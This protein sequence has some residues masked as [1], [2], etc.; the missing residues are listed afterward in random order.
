MVGTIGPFRLLPSL[1]F[2]MTFSC[3]QIRLATINHLPPNLIY[4]SASETAKK[5]VPQLR[6]QG[7]EIIIA[8]THAREPNDMKLAENTPEGLIDLIACG[9]DHFYSHK[10]V[11][12]THILRS[13]TDFKQLSYIE[14]WRAVPGKRFAWDFEITRRDIV[15]S[16]PEDPETVKLVESLTSSLQHKLE[17][18]VGHTAVPLDSRFTTVRTKESNLGNWVCD[19][20]R[21]FYAADC[22]IMAAGTIRGDQIYPPGSILLKDVMN[23]FPFEDPVV[24]LRVTGSAIWSALENSVCLYPAL[25]GRFAQ[26][27]NIVFEFDPEAPANSRITD[28]KMG[29]K[30]IDRSSNQLYSLAT[31]GY[32][33]RGKDG[34]GSLLCASEG[35]IAEEIVTEENG[36][37][38]ST[39]IRQYFMSLKVF[40]KWRCGK[41]VERHWGS[42]KKNLHQGDKI[43]NAK[44]VPDVQKGTKHTGTGSV[45][46]PPN[47]VG[48]VNDVDDRLVGSD[49]DDE[50]HDLPSASA[51][52]SKDDKEPQLNEFQVSEQRE[53][54][55]KKAI[56]VI[57]YWKQRAKIDRASDAVDGHGDE[58]MPHWTQAIAPRVEGRI[59]L[60]GEASK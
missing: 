36:M 32:M 38:I 59:R 12:K 17:K 33:A 34:F 55:K 19:L 2:L 54:A 51:R 43:R 18:P 5:L 23:C 42:V 20:M 30:S 22:A 21:H 11:K 1:P 37:L 50:G 48:K 52:Q 58:D 39:I 29:G 3:F 56:A 16:I 35:G 60:K 27:S 31:R 13:G 24:V 41:S 8:L 7:C 45:I 10:V 47:H 57:R 49:S 4:K 53:Y 6:A 44:A 14:A 46:Q 15:R 9:H 26:V 25:E 28:L 40:G